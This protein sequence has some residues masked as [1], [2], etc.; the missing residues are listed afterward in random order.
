MEEKTWGVGGG[1]TLSLP[2][3]LACA[4]REEQLLGQ[5]K[6]LLGRA[7]RVMKVLTHVVNVVTCDLDNSQCLPLMGL[8]VKAFAIE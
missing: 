8:S 3:R 5:L 1:L 7:T 4:S 2:K 6:F